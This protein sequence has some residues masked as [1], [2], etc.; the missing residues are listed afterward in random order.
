[1]PNVAKTKSKLIRLPLPKGAK[2]RVRKTSQFLPLPVTSRSKPE[3]KS[4]AST[5]LKFDYHGVD[6]DKV[7]YSKVMPKRTASD[8][9][10]E[11]LEKSIGAVGLIT[12]ILVRRNLSR[13]GHY[14]VLSGSRRLA[15]CVSL[16]KTKKKHGHAAPWYRK[17][18]TEGPRRSIRDVAATD[19]GELDCAGKVQDRRGT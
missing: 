6:I 5:T 2:R 14:E 3:L 7:H 11:K 13:P 8:A 15:A 10:Q 18:A 12:P 16:G 9:Q 17:A 1:M 19:P 4:R